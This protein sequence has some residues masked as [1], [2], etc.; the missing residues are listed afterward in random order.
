MTPDTSLRARMGFTLIEV[1]TALMVM[2][3]VVRLGI[4]NY[5]EVRTRAEA[6]SAAGDFHVVRQ[7]VMAYQA[8]NNAWPPD[9][10]PGQT[11]PELAD[12]LPAEFS[13]NRGLYR[14]DWENWS[15]PSGLPSHPQV[16]SVLA[17]SVV[18]ENR[19][20][21]AAL[22]DLLGS[23]TPHFSLTGNYTFVLNTQ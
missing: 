12:Y 21:G 22:A 1:L 4:P 14:L 16:R 13:F 7:A 8:D 17:V 11:P 3:V 9:L 6:A 18:T 20:L 19:A 10:G 23:S 2:S 15:L 5:Q